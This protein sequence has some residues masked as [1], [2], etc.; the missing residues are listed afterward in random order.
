[1]H[2]SLSAC[3]REVGVAGCLSILSFQQ[4]SLSIYEAKYIGQ[5]QDT[6]ESV[7]LRK[8]LRELGR[9]QLQAAVIFG[10][11]Q[12]AIALA[13]NPQFHGRSKHIDT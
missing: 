13:K 12:G 1:M 8:L 11:N 4:I 6:K 9:E 10:D 3:R 5:T 7:W 2:P